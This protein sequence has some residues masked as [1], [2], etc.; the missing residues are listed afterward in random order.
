MGRRRSERRGPAHIQALHPPRTAFEL[1]PIR[2]EACVLTLSAPDTIVTPPGPSWNHSD[3]RSSLRRPLLIAFAVGL[4]FSTFGNA[5]AAGLYD[6]DWNG[7][8]TATRGPQCAAGTVALTVLGKQ[9]TGEARLGP[10]ARTINGTVRPDGTFGGTIGFQHLT[11]K[12][13]DDTF[14]GTF[15]GLECAWIMKL[16]RRRPRTPTS[17]RPHHP[18]RAPLL[19]ALLL[20]P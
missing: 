19:A 7:S 17:D 9:A 15:Q 3:S 8:A 18:A 5:L 6:G 11:G 13:I 12:F 10:D 1:R 14:E 16:K 2:K 4:V 20:L